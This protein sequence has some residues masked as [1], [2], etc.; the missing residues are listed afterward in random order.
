MGQHHPST[1]LGRL[2]IASGAITPE[3]LQEA[4]Y[5]QKHCDKPI[6]E[7][8]VAMGALAPRQLERALRAQA[9]LRGRPSPDR[10]F[11]LVVDD[12]PE[13]GAIVGDILAGAGYRV[14]VAQ[15]EAEAIAAV[16]AEDGQRP[17]LIVL[18]LGL[19]EYGGLEFLTLLRKNGETRNTP[20]VILTGRPDLE[21]KVRNSGLPISAFVAKPVA[22]RS[23]LKIVEAAL[24]KAEPE[25]A[26]AGSPV[27]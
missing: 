19:P 1:L 26:P 10:A 12:D 20:V 18:D 27:A 3:D 25:V 21:D 7:I 24:A 5:Q 11:L 14:G 4:L 9:R 15:N 22:A 2:L 6:G 8:L 23:L 13:V 17:A 16:F